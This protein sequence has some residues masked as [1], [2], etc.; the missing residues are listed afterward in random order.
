MCSTPTKPSRDSLTDQ[1][2]RKLSLKGINLKKL[3]LRHQP[4]FRDLKILQ[5]L[6]MH[7]ETTTKKNIDKANFFTD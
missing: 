7:V 3:K 1:K 2:G 6:K 4:G 5:K